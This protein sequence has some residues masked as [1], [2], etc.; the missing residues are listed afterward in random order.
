[1]LYLDVFEKVI[2]VQDIRI[3]IQVKRQATIFLDH[4]TLENGNIVKFNVNINVVL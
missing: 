3:K 1:M 4:V 2:H